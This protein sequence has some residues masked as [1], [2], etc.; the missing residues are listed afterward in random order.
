MRRVL[1]KER[2]RPLKVRLQFGPI[3]AILGTVLCVCPL[4]QAQRG[5]R[6]PIATRSTS[7]GAVSSS[8]GSTRAAAVRGAN[9]RASSASGFVRSTQRQSILGPINRHKPS[10]IPN[11]P[12]RST[13]GTNGFYLLYGGGTYWVPANSDEAT[14]QASVDQPNDDEAG[15]DQSSDQSGRNQSQRGNEVTLQTQDAQSGEED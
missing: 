5:S 14:D 10:P 7:S 4:A 8:A 3:L 1:W 13:A 15:G 6:A 2:K 9:V 11:P 12:S